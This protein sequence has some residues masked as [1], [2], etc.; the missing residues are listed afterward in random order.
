[1]ETDDGFDWKPRALPKL[2]VDGGS[3][4]VQGAVRG[5]QKAQDRQ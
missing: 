3:V 2:V 5:D 1:M 4:R